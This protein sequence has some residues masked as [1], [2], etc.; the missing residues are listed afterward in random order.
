MDDPRS[1]RP[2]LFIVDDDDAFRDSLS[3]LLCGQDFD[4]ETSGSVDD[5]LRLLPVARPACALVDL[6]MPRRC[7]LDLLAALGDARAA[8]PVIMM[9]GAGDVPSAVRAMQ[10]GAIDFIEKPLDRDALLRAV[11]DAFARSRDA[12]SRLNDQHAFLRRLERLTERERD[13]FESLLRGS[14]NKEIA[15]ELGISP[16]T[17]EIHRA[18]VMQKLEMENT[19]QLVRAAMRAHVAHEEA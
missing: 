18:R 13:V 4:V 3:A 15:I 2:L 16:R 8:V 7:G 6:H 5:F 19:T 17:V 9:T 11:R 12:A 10:A 14:S 1:A